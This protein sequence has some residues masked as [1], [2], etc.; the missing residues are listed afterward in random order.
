LAPPTPLAKSLTL[1]RVASRAAND[2]RLAPRVV[3]ALRELLER[4]TLLL[5]LHDLVVVYV[6]ASEPDEEDEGEAE[7]DEGDAEK[8]GDEAGNVDVPLGDVHPK[9]GLGVG[10][11]GIGTRTIGDHPNPENTTPVFLKVVHIDHAPPALNG[12]TSDDP[13]GTYA[14]TTLGELGCTVDPRTTRVAMVG[15]EHAVVPCL[16]PRDEDEE[17]DVEGCMCLT[18]LPVL[19]G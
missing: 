9:L 3:R 15:V 12:S 17:G 1:A 18:F 8:A 14:A 5:K 10:G 11:S 13:T 7:G 6:D 16:E 2:R 4:T 19:S